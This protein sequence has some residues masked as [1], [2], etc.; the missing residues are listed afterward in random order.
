MR[1]PEET[2]DGLEILD[3]ANNVVEALIRGGELTAAQVADEV[4]EPLSSTY[5]LMRHLQALGWV[6]QGT[7]RGLYRL[8]LDM[9]RIASHVEDSLDLRTL[10]LPTLRALRDETS[11]SSFLCIRRGSQGV[12]IERLDGTAVRAVKPLLG[13]A[14]P[15]NVGAA[16][17]AILANLPNEEQQRIIDE[18][19]STESSE[20]KGELT[21]RLGTVA[22]QGFAIDV[23]GIVPGIASVGAAV[24]NHRGEVIGAISVSGLKTTLLTD[25]DLVSLVV[26][27]AQKVSQTM[28]WQGQSGKI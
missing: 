3:K 4:G 17:T 20:R 7:K 16:P 21:S 27:C 9:M 11:F 22:E 19:L 25:A 1:V 8:G 12:F 24:R 13:D 23:E 28:G 10:A 15:L 26:R 14:V 6:Q 5:R 2:V 18:L